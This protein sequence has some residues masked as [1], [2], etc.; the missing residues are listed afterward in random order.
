MVAIEIKFGRKKN[1]KNC[2][3]NNLIKLIFKIKCE[4]QF[5]ILFDALR[6]G[7]EQYYRKW[8]RP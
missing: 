8:I 2:I 5:F 3:I 7:T 6:H 4:A 1:Y